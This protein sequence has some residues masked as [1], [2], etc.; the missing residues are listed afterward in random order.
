M[1]TVST[2]FSNPAPTHPLT[3]SRMRAGGAAAL[4]IVKTTPVIVALQIR[5]GGRGRHGVC[6]ARAWRAARGVG[7]QGE[8]DG[9]W[10]GSGAHACG[11]APSMPHWSS[12]QRAFHTPD[13]PCAPSGSAQRSRACFTTSARP[14]E[15]GD[16]AAASTFGQR[17]R[18][19]CVVCLTYAAEYAPDAA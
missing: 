6:P 3:H 7:A 9:H 5:T 12:L 10:Q 18:H 19:G 15:I 2:S 11:A 1:Q 17:V 4:K 13:A 16:A 14:H 8:T